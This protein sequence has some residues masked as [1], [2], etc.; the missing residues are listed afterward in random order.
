M[1][2]LTLPQFNDL[3]DRIYSLLMQS[4]ELGMGDMGQAHEAAEIVATEWTE[5]NGIEIEN[6]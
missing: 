6:A 2:T 1:K 5:A 3:V 4:D